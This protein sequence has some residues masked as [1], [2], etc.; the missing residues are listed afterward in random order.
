MPTGIYKRTKPAWNAGLRGEDFLK[1]FKDGKVW[2]SGLAGS[3]DPRLAKHG[4]YPRTEFHKQVCIA[5][6]GVYCQKGNIP[7]NKGLTK[8][9]HTGIA[10]GA[11]KARQFNLG[12]HHSSETRKKMS[13]SSPL[14][15]KPC[16]EEKKQNLREKNKGQ[17]PWSKGLSKETDERILSQSL[18]IAGIWKDIDT[19]N[20]WL[21]KLRKAANQRPNKLEI[22]LGE[23]L[24]K[25]FPNEWLYTGNGLVT[26]GGMIPDFANINGHKAVVEAFGD[27]WH[28]DENPQNRIDR[29]SEFGYKCAV[30]WENEI[31]KNPALVIE[32]IKNMV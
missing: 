32:R 11:E 10:R 1:H 20:A 22:L 31:K 13:L 8:E 29:Y 15:G 18:K 30:V 23:L 28:K 5:N 4:I 2:N 7:W 9:N 16:S 25:A 26:I 12:R 24:D 21:K 3:S 6:F 27:F 19:K 17:V 14:R